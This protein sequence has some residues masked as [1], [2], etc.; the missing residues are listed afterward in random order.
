MKLTSI[1]RNSYLTTRNIIKFT[2]RAPRRT[3][4]DAP[5][6]EGPNAYVDTSVCLK[7]KDSLGD[8]IKMRHHYRHRHKVENSKVDD[9]IQENWDKK[10]REDS[11]PKIDQI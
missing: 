11:N 3:Q 7:C 9:T 10:W 1:N 2:F 8:I 4:A 5:L 6:W